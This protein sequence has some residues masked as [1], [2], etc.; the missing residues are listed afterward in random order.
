MKTLTQEQ[1]DNFTTFI[2]EHE[3]FIITGH[4]EPDGDC[5]SSCLGISYILDYYNKPYLLLNAGPFK[6]NEIKKFAPKFRQEVPFMTKMDRD[7]C[8]LI[9]TDC[10]ELNRLGEISEDLKDMDTFII[11]HHKTSD[12]SAKNTIIDSTAP[13][14]ACLVQLLFEATAK[15]MNKDIAKTFF[16]GI[17]TDTGYFRFLTNENSEVFNLVSRLVKAGANPREIYQEISSGKSWNTRKLLAIMLQ[18]AEKHLSGKL[19]VTWET[20]EDTKK[21]GATGR[22]SDALYSLML[23]VENV[24]AV[25]FLRQETE[26]TCTL[27]LRSKDSWDVSEIATKF[28]GGG[29]KNA[30]GASTEGEIKTLLPKIIQEFSKLNK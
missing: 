24:E 22:D 20:M 2:K 21:Y 23:E 13:A 25:V 7:S 16:F 14:A 10:S 5:I 29:H 1:I 28:G 11:D 19:I 12:G 26:H 6:R 3:T 9:I 17:A 8:G 30:S 15:N 27:G 4:K 18:R